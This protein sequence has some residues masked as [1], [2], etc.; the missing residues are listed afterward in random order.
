MATITFDQQKRQSNLLKHGLDLADAALV[1]DAPNKITLSSPRHGEDRK[2]DI[3]LVEIL[4]V[5]LA[6]A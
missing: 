6:L 3:A 1:F 5:V 4:N 2:Q